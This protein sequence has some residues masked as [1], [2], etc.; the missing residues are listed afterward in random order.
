[1]ELLYKTR[2][3]SLPYGKSRIYFTCHPKEFDKTFKVISDDILNMIDCAIY[4]SEDKQ[5]E[6]TKEEFDVELARM[7]LIVIPVTYQLLMT[8]NKIMDYE[9]VYAKREHIPILPIVMEQG[10]GT[11]Y[12][13]NELLGNLQYLDRYACDDTQLTYEDKLKNYLQSVIISNELAMKVRAA[14]DAYIFLSY[15]KKDRYHANELMRI[16]H[17]NPLCRDIAIWYDEYLV[18]GEYYNLAI[19][20]SLKISFCTSC[21]PKFDK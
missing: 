10:I 19:S 4:Y 8:S 11:L 14:F 12:Q 17:K 16:I 3:E 18:L 21:N 6:E 2:G 5:V 9:I 7:N 1:M 13:E 20:E 15:R